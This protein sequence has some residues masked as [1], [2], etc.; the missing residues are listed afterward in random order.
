MSV[1]KFE[2]GV[3]DLQNRF[4]QESAAAEYGRFLGQQRF[5]RDRSDMND[6]FTKGFPK[7]TGRLAR[8]FGSDVRSGLAGR[9][10]ADVTNRYAQQL[11]DMDTEQ[12][13]FEANFAGSQAARQAAYQ[14]SLLA[15]QEEYARAQLAQNPFT[16]YGGV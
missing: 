5:S 2:S 10:V 8:R 12:A 9:E 15:L 3:A 14:R 6:R 11:T 7:V 1:F 16:M 13:G 4:A